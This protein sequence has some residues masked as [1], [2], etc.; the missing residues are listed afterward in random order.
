[1]DGTLERML[2]EQVTAELREKQGWPGMVSTSTVFDQVRAERLPFLLLP[3]DK[4]RLPAGETHEGLVRVRE[5]VDHGYL[6]IVPQRPV[7]LAGLPRFAWWRIDP[8]SGETVGV[9]D[10]GLH[11]GVEL[12]IEHN[13]TTGETKIVW[14]EFVGSAVNLATTQVIEVATGSTQMGMFLGAL[15]TVARVVREIVSGR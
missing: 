4:D 10:D 7:H 11:Q 1:M 3:R 12:H 8:R 15:L 13:K 9:T 6:A 5:E 2:I 14:R